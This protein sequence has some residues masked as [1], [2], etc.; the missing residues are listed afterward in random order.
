MVCELQ[1]M[2]LLVALVL[3]LPS[4]RRRWIYHPEHHLLVST[5]SWACPGLDLLQMISVIIMFTD[6]CVSN[7]TS[8]TNTISEVWLRPVL[9]S[10]L[11][12]V[13]TSCSHQI[14]FFSLWLFIICLTEINIFSWIKE[15]Q[16]SGNSTGKWTSYWLAHF[17]QWFDG[18][19]DAASTNI[20]PPWIYLTN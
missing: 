7:A 9:I 8:T 16:R 6:V 4:K 15:I 10:C 11:V 20:S 1:L 13:K 2:Q 17:F 18:S 19:K 3:R 12:A 5:D 14:D